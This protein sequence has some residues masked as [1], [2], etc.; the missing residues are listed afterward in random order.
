MTDM[1]G[2]R[3]PVCG[4]VFITGKDLTLL[5]EHLTLTHPLHGMLRFVP[6]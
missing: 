3:C 4:Q 6:L 5:M 2:Y 1:A